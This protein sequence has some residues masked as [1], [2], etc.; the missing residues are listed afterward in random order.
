GPGRTYRAVA[1]R[2][3]EG[4]GALLGPYQMW[5]RRSDDPNDTVPHE[6]RRD[7]RGMFVFAAWLNFS[8]ARAVTTQDILTTVDGG[9]RIRHS[10]VDL[11]KSLGSSMFDGPKL[12]W[13]GNETLVTSR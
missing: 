13:E 2:I 4:R 11:T 10:V 1:T 9:S 8:S 3:P 5:G 6:H 7:L 12:A